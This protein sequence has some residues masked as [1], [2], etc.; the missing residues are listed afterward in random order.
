MLTG[1]P[2]PGGEILVGSCF[3]GGFNGVVADEP[4]D[5]PN[6]PTGLH[7]N[8]PF[9]YPALMWERTSFGHCAHNAMSLPEGEAA[10]PC[11]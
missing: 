2:R 5:Y 4:L 6:P 9:I 11:G 7:T 1:N 3:V 8:G 10:K